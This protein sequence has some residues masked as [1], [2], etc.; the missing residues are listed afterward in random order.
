[1]RKRTL[2]T[3]YDDLPSMG[4]DPCPAEVA[5]AALSAR[6]GPIPRCE[7]CGRFK[8]RGLWAFQEPQITAIVIQDQRLR[9]QSSSVEEDAM[10][11]LRYR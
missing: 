8:S 1:V 5:A 3:S 7:A 9:G 11:S 10:D 2:S 4:W 6:H